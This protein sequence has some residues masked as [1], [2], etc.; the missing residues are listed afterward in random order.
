L[1]DKYGLRVNLTA[2]TSSGSFVSLRLK[3]ADGEK[4]KLLLGDKPVTIVFGNAVLETIN[5]K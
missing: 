3:I 4:A 1:E 2:V 5:A